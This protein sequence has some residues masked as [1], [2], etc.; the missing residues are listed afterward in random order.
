LLQLP[1]SWLPR[2]TGRPEATTMPA[3]LAPAAKRGSPA[4]AL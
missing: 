4:L 2:G 3:P 1:I